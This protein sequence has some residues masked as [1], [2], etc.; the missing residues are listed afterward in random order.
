V[1]SPERLRMLDHLAALAG[2]A[3][4]RLAPAAPPVD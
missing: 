2:A 1:V 3:F 4:Q